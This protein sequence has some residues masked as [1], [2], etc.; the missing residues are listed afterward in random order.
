MIVLGLTGSIA[1]GKT[2]VATMFARHGVPVFSADSAVHAAYANEGRAP[3][4]KAFPRA[5]RRDGMVDRARIGTIVGENR[6][7]LK[8]LEDILHPLVRV[9]AQR[10]IDEARKKGADIA[11]LEI[12]LLFETTS[13]YPIDK[14]VVTFCPE[15]E[16]E[17]RALARPG[18]TREKLAAIRANQLPQDEKRARAD[19]AINTGG[20]F[21]EVAEQVSRILTE[22]RLGEEQDAAA[23]T[24]V[25]SDAA[26]EPEPG[27][28][29]D[30]ELA[31]LL[32]EH[33]S[34]FEEDYAG[35]DEDEAVEDQEFEDAEE[36]E[37]EDEVRR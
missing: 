28:G 10:F 14:S 6:K 35:F 4:A 13:R 16:L 30:A 17:R 8:K 19:F 25:E 24:P 34:R 21:S 22:L 5:V 18:M 37:A 11:V 27:E 36:P 26:V 23:G 20:T 31:E 3:L 29:A 33:E 2:T 1:T 7:L 9:R 32:R 15:D 12:P